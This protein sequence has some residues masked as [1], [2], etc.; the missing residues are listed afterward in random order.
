MP[1]YSKYDKD[2]LVKIIN[3][4]DK[5]LKT[6]KYGLVWDSEREPE[7]V[8]LDCENNLPILKR[9][10]SKKIITNNCE[11]NILI[12]G[13]NYH[14]L[15][16]L[17]YTHQEKIDV[18]Y[19]DPPYNTGNK[20]WKY[21]NN[22]V[23]KED[24]YRHS[25]WLNMMEKRLNLAKRLLKK[26]GCL[27]CAIDENEHA[28]LGLLL[29]KIFP[30]YKIDCVTIIHNPGGIQGENFSYTHEYAYFVYPDLAGYI[31]RVERQDVSPVSLRDWGG[32]ESKRETSKNSF[33][34]I[35]VKDMEIIDF[36][37]VCDVDFHPGSSNVEIEKDVTAIYPIDNSGVER[38]WRHAR[39]SIEEIKEELKC[40]KIKGELVIKR[41]KTVF[42]Y[43]TVWADKKYTANI[44]GSKL[45][46][47]IIGTEFPFPKSLYNVEECLLAVA[48]NKKNAIVLDF[49][50]GSGTT[51]HAVLKMN[52]DDGG[53]RKFILCTNNEGNICK[54]VTYPRMHNVI[55]GYKY[56]GKDRKTLFEKRLTFSS[57]YKNIKPRKGETKEEF[58]KR[59]KATLDKNIIQVW[60]EIDKIITENTGSYDGFEKVF[61][62]NIIEIVGIKN[63]KSKKPGL[64]GNLQYFQTSLI[65]RSKNRDQVKVDLT[66]KCTEMLCLRE[67]IFNLK[68]EEPD[69]KVF[70]SNKNDVYLCVY[71][72]FID[73]SFNDFLEEIKKLTGKKYIYMFS[74]D[75]KVGKSLFAGIR[76]I[77]IEP[78]P[79]MILDIYK[80][81]VKMNIPVKANV[82]FTDLS[83]ANTKIF[84]DKDKDDGA[85]ILRVVIEKLIQKISQDNSINI[86]NAQGKEIK[87]SSL[88]DKLKNSNIITKIEWEENK[89]FLAIGNYAAHGEYG[90]YDLGQVKRF[91]KHI[92][93][94]LNS[95]NI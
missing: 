67:N 88:N 18:I 66:Q 87:T 27:I 23:E 13:D 60:L 16:V 74:I 59:K 8:V 91:Y 37:E 25:K 50:A 44:Y 49:F 46:K 22:Y 19:I 57:L 69:F 24:G 83:K 53:N 32:D 17:S 11:D 39:Q 94:L 47:E 42:R 4:Q 58:K 75:N 1:D 77:T 43:K 20:S 73:D 33:Y 30:A 72:N 12:E 78:I 93:S 2:Q 90:E 82:I 63:I 61:E 5:E 76:D 62:D 85:R 6:K 35:Y 10:K 95:Y 36:G 65:K 29:K 79:Q 45:V 64:G 41:Y 40:E 56:K 15:T 80:K 51:G 34:P 54:D 84:K 68:I 3:R 52:K 81:L 38:K 21:N 86:L 55:K 14:A 28:N 70:S 48:K 31:S 71:Y 89:T 92:Q 7:Q 9:L 26:D